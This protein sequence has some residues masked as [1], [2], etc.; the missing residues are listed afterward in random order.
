MSAQLSTYEPFLTLHRA[1][2]L[3]STLRKRKW[4]LQLQPKA[5]ETLNLHEALGTFRRHLQLAFARGGNASLS[6]LFRVTKKIIKVNSF[7][8]FSD[9]QKSIFR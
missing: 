5:E 3:H 4:N 9:L 8:R 2:R 1:A 6:L 7:T